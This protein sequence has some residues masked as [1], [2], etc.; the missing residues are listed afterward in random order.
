MAKRAKQTFVVNGD[1]RNYTITP[2]QIFAD[3]HPLT[4]A[5]ADKFATIAELTATALDTPTGVAESNLTATS[6]TVTW[7]AVDGATSYTVTTTPA[8]ATYN[9]TEPEVELT[10]LTPET[11][12]TVSV[13]AKNGN[14]YQTD[15]SAGTDT[16]TTPAE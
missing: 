1:G 8:T 16:L 10:D 6:A 13:V 7:D 5:H 3:S 12:Y 11:G 15:S 4:S 14:P 2:S 9:V